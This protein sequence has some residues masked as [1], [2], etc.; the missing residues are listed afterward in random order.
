MNKKIFYILATVV[1]LSI[2]VSGCKEKKAVHVKQPPSVL[3]IPAFYKLES[4]EEKWMGEVS[5]KDSTR[6][7]ARVPGYLTKQYIN[8]GQMVKRGDFI[9]Q[10]EKAQYE[11][12]LQ[13]AKSKLDNYQVT[14]FTNT[15][16]YKRMLKLVKENAVSKKNFDTAQCNYKTAQANASGAEAK[17]KLAEMNLGYTNI[18][19]P[20]DGQLGISKYSPGALVGPGTENTAALNSIVKMDPVRID[21]S[22]AEATL[23]NVMQHK[24]KE[25]NKVQQK[26]I[27]KAL[28]SIDVNLILSNGTEYSSTGKINFVDNHVNPTTGTVLIRALFENPDYL[29]RPGAF[30]TVHISTQKKHKVLLIPR[31]SVIQNQSS[32][33]VLSVN[34]KNCVVSNNIT[35]GNIFGKYIEVT[36]GLNKNDL[37]IKQGIQ[38]VKEGMKVSCKIAVEPDKS[39]PISS[40]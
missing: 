18:T 10:I 1:L 2:T 16:E 3:V 24:Y 28:S 11:A 12:D 5:A 26:D 39:F 30:V 38:K 37:V 34:N 23:V 21:F 32:S 15:I 7:Y 22:V 35:T 27:I 20:F 6:L 25:L 33:Y 14:L 13:Y 19:A 29:L 9:Y 31:A 8:D 4:I 40:K 17:V 36:N